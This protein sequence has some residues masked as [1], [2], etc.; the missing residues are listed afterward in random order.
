MK[1][2]TGLVLVG[3]IIGAGFGAR[4]LRNSYM[5]R[6]A[7]NEAQ[8]LNNERNPW[9]MQTSALD[10]YSYYTTSTNETKFVYGVG[11]ETNLVS[12]D[13]LQNALDNL[14][15]D[16]LTEVGQMYNSMPG[17]NMESY[18]G[19]ADTNNPYWQQINQAIERDAASSP[20]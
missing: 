18:F 13:M 3:A 5:Q 12:T 19:S 20:E 14:H 1:V 8:A 11:N 6:A 17:N 4:A 16:I 10:A 9:L 15:S 2:T 7:V